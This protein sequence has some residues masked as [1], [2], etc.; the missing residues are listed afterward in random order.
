VNGGKSGNP[1]RHDPNL[2]WERMVVLRATNFRVPVAT[3]VRQYEEDGMAG[4]MDDVAFASAGEPL[5]T[6]TANNNLVVARTITVPVNTVTQLLFRWTAQDTALDTLVRQGRMTV[7]RKTAASL[8]TLQAYADDFTF[9][10][11]DGTWDAD[12]NITGADV[13]QRLKGDGTNSTKHVTQVWAHPSPL[14]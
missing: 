3:E 11:I 5:L 6:I 7:M 8:T 9:H 10:R 4:M 13:Q 14:L 12:T 1:P 2:I